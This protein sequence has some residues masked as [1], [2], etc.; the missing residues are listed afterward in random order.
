LN[1]PVR[2]IFVTGTD[3]EIGKTYV[4]CVILS[5]WRAQGARVAAM[6]PIAAGLVNGESENLR[7]LEAAAQTRIPNACVY[8]L[9]DPIAPHIAAQRAGVSLSASAIANDFRR[10]A[11]EFDGI[12]VEGAG[13]AL[14]PLNDSETMLDIATAC[15][16]PVL[17]VVGMRLGCINHALLTYHAIEQ[18]GLDCAGWVANVL[19]P[20]MP[21]LHDNVETLKTRMEAPFWGI[22]G[23]GKTRL[24]ATLTGG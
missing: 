7:A 10:S 17:I 14:V 20:E 12:L 24:S 21:F 9:P 23:Y 16:L 4:S 19:N 22:C 5:T 15:A 3:T 8:A 18:K 11:P 1:I 6:K 13:G 2:S